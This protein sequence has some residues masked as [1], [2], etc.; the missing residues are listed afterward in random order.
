MEGLS[1]AGTSE[2]RPLGTCLDLG[3]PFGTAAAEV[4]DTVTLFEFAVV[5]LMAVGAELF[6]F[7]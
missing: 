7:F 5:R 1:S 4:R 2:L 3:F 6:L